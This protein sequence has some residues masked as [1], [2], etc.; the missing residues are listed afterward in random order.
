MSKK[1]KRLKFKKVY[2]SIKNTV[3][4]Y[5]IFNR[6]KYL[7]TN[8]EKIY[9]K[10]KKKIKYIFFFLLCFFLFIFFCMILLKNL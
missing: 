5:L 7:I 8:D 6:I 10:K 3:I 9:I 1:K 4:I 2:I